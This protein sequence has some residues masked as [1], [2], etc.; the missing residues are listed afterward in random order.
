M[1]SSLPSGWRRTS[2]Q[3]I[4]SDVPGAIA[5]GPF[6][7]RLKSDKYVRDGVPV[8]RGTN[9]KGSRYFDEAFVY[10][11]ETTAEELRSCIVTE[12]DLVFPHRG[13]IGEVGIVQRQHPRYLLSTSMM[14]F[15]CNRNDADPLY[16]YY[17]FRSPT[18]RHELLQNASQVGTPGIATPL[19]SLKSAKIILPPLRE[20]RAIASALGALEDKI[21]LNRHMNH[22]LE[23]IARAIFQS[24]FV[25][26]DPVWAKQEGRQPAGIDADT[27][28]LFPNDFEESELGPIPKGWRVGPLTDIIDIN[29]TRRVSRGSEATFVEMADMPTDGPR[30]LQTTKRLVD[31]SGARFQSGDVLLA[32][33]TPSLEHGKTAYVDFLPDRRVGFGSTEFIVMH[34]RQ[35]F[36][37]EYAYFIARDPN[38]RAHAIQNMSGTSGRQRVPAESL[39]YYGLV[40]P[41]AVVADRF[42][43]IARN[44][45]AKIRANDEESRTLAAIRDTL[46]PKLISGEIRIKDAEKIVGEAV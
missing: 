20:Q 46:L 1:A 29:P 43:L 28:A 38:F 17:Y 42:G 27:V 30:V 15:T 21:E 16:V 10:V 22:S 24:W 34:S 36:P 14:K 23:Q 19:T 32:R 7:S 37:P 35:G 41:D 4:A 13:A 45:F 2:V 8:I 26:F 11:S 18:G 39:A 12:G 9:L 3:A 25:D 33:I 5:I 31:G 40:Q 44:F 6:G